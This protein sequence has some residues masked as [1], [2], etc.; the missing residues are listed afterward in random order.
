MTPQA[1]FALPGSSS[2]CHSSRV[3]AYARAFNIDLHLISDRVARAIES[4]TVAH[5]YTEA[6]AAKQMGVT[7]DDLHLLLMTRYAEDHQPLVVAQDGFYFSRPLGG[8]PVPGH[9]NYH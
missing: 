4:A 8:W 7:E 3:K 9:R 5:A 2:N 1:D 6:Q